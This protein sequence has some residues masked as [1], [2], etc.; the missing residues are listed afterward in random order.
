MMISLRNVSVAAVPLCLACVVCLWNCESL[1]GASMENKDNTPQRSPASLAA[2]PQTP[3]TSPVRL[4]RALS[5][6]TLTADL[7]LA[8][9]VATWGQPDRDAG[10]G[11]E[12][13]AYLL[14]DGRWLMFWFGPGQNQSGVLTEA[15]VYTNDQDEEG[16]VLFDATVAAMRATKAPATRPGK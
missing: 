3:T 11:R 14:A 7:T 1:G 9:V 10:S 6:I 2:A 16:I 8:Q 13:P 12:I 5:D 4:Q 15:V